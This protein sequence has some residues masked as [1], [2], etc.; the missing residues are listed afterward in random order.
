MTV[1]RTFRNKLFLFFWLMCMCFCLWKEGFQNTSFMHYIGTELNVVNQ[2]SKWKRIWGRV[3]GYVVREGGT[4]DLQRS[5]ALLVKTSKH[6]LDYFTFFSSS[7]LFLYCPEMNYLIF[8]FQVF[9]QPL[10]VIEFNFSLDVYCA[11]HV[12]VLLLLS[13]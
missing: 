13:F 4:K 1:I 7:P 11:S 12:A 3:W 6:L 5:F 10:L 9:G 2:H 8:E